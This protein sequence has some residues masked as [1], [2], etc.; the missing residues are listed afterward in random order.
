[1]LENLYMFNNKHTWKLMAESDSI[2]DLR[3]TNNC[4]SRIVGQACYIWGK[5]HVS[6]DGGILLA[7]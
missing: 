1:M 4:V 3:G 6:V 5:Q 2:G 7:F